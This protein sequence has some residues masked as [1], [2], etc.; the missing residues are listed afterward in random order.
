[1]GLLQQTYCLTNGLG[2]W[3]L[4]VVRTIVRGWDDFGLEHMIVQDVARYVDEHRALAARHSAAQSIVH[5]FWNAL[6]FVHLNS[7]LGHRLE[8]VEQVEFLKGVLVVMSKRWATSDC[9]YW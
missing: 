8:H 2:M 5:D 6:G 9:H 4:R 7:Q 1:F 3:Q